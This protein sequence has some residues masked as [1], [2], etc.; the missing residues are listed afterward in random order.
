MAWASKVAAR[1]PAKSSRASTPGMYVSIG[2]TATTCT[3][4]RPATS[5][6]R[7]GQTL[8]FQVMPPA[9]SG[10]AAST[11]DR[12]PMVSGGG[13]GGMAPAV[14]VS[15]PSAAGSTG[16][17]S[18]AGASGAS[19]ASDGAAGGG[20]HAASVSPAVPRRPAA[21]SQIQPAPRRRRFSGPTSGSFGRSP[22]E[23]S[24]SSVTRTHR[25]SPAAPTK[26]VSVAGRE[27]TRT[28][29]S[30]SEF[31]GVS[32][33]GRGIRGSGL[34]STGGSAS[35]ARGSSR[36]QQPPRATA[37]VVSV[38]SRNASR[39]DSRRWRGRSAS[40][41]TVCHDRPGPRDGDRPALRADS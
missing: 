18:T 27:P 12:R 8:P 41:C 10:T 16:S 24:G 40:M 22:G 37:A 28:R 31:G 35:P 26:M 25:G 39:R 34:G 4:S 36:R 32:S 9:G 29:T 7:P 30:G 13:A 20:G 11:S 3:R 21:S 1:Q 5:R 17:G 33:R 23:S 6:S 19:G 15:G 14:S 38:P 2:T